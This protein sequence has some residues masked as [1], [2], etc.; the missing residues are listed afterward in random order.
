MDTLQP[1]RARAALS[2]RSA[3]LKIH[4]K[5]CRKRNKARAMSPVKM[6]RADLIKY[7]TIVDY[8]RTEGGSSLTAGLPFGL[9]YTYTFT[10]DKR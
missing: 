5:A 4:R 7:F 6:R 10:Q 3:E 2:S 8:I 9:G 1:P